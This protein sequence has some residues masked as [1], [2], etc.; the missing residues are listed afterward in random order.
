MAKE[1]AECFTFVV[2]VVEEEPTTLRR[3]S[4]QL[5]DMEEQQPLGAIR[6]ELRIFTEKEYASLVFYLF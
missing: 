4:V 1:R 2:D 6:G 3:S 5:V